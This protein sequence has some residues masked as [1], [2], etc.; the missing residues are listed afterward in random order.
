MW[1]GATIATG[2]TVAVKESGRTHSSPPDGR[3]PRT[4][5][6]DNEFQIL[7]GL[8]H[9]SIP[10]VFSLFATN[11]A[12]YMSLQY[13]PGLNV[14]EELMSIGALPEPT[15]RRRAQQLVSAVAYIHECHLV[16]RDVKPQNMMIASRHGAELILLIDFGF[17]KRPPCSTLLGTPGYLAPEL[18]DS[19]LWA[20]ATW[21]Y[22][23]PVD[24][25]APGVTLYEMLSATPPFDEYFIVQQTLQDDV[26]FDGAEWSAVS[27]GAREVVSLLLIKDA[28]QRVSSRAL[29]AVDWIAQGS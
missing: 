25:W 18:C 23:A 12:V 20:S 10:R 14:M 19:A 24:L 22:S 8:Q 1:R 5:P 9:A 4:L 13:I 3:R 7:S 17:T 28:A 26:R 2:E 29:C 27:A 15:V 11:T 6:D 16:H 21:S